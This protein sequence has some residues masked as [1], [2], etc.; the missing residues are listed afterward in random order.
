MQKFLT[1]ICLI[2]MYVLVCGTL[3]PDVTPLIVNGVR[4]N[5]TEFPWHASMY[6]ES[7]S[8]IKKYFCGASI[9]QENLLITAA[10][11]VYDENTRKII[12]N[13]RQIYILTGNIFRNYD[14]PLHDQRLVRKGQV[15]KC[16]RNITNR[17]HMIINPGVLYMSFYR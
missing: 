12:E 5:I 3:P 16:K 10:H 13:P 8:G 15:C 6:R 17:R 9:I 2:A 4:P 11:C 14:S 1:V 7:A